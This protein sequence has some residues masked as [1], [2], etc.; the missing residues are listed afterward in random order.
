MYVRMEV[1][2]SKSCAMRT[3]PSSGKY[4][5]KTDLE[6]VCVRGEDEVTV[7]VGCFQLP[8]YRLKYKSKKFGFGN[9]CKFMLVLMWR[10]LD[11]IQLEIANNFEVDIIAENYNL[12]IG[13]MYAIVP[14]SNCQIW[15]LTILGHEHGQ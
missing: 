9:L 6:C 10:C 2:P 3:S 8:N 1:S 12:S 7:G 4:V 13:F 15:S 14:K 11:K 5:G